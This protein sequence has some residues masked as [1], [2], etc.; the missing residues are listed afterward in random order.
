MT[1]FLEDAALP[2]IVVGPQENFA[3]AWLAVICASVAIDGKCPFA[4]EFRARA[5]RPAGLEAGK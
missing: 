3:F 5:V 4:C 2:S 1:W